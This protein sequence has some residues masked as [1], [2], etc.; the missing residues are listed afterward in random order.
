MWAKI[1]QQKSEPKED[2]QRYPESYPKLHLTL[3]THD[4][5][6]VHTWKITLTETIENRRLQENCI[7]LE[8]DGLKRLKQVGND[9]HTM[10]Y[11][12]FFVFNKIR[13]FIFT[14]NIEI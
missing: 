2:E 14:M 8:P 5:K 4:Q 12:D 6:E 3:P 9:T 13:Q 10:L 1:G 7:L 11:D